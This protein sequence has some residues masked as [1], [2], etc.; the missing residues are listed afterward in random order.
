MK[1]NIERSMTVAGEITIIG[2]T[3][4]VCSRTLTLLGQ[5]STSGSKT[6][7]LLG[8]TR[9][10]QCKLIFSVT[11]SSADASQG[12]ASG[13]GEVEYGQSITIRAAA[14]SGYAF[15]HWT[16]NGAAVQGAGAVYSYAPKGND[17][18]VAYFKDTPVVFDVVAYP[19]VVTD[20][21]GNMFW[22]VS[23]ATN[24]DV[25]AETTLEVSGFIEISGGG[26]GSFSGV[27]E[28]G[29]GKNIL[30]TS[31]P[32]AEG[33]DNVIGGELQLQCTDASY[34]VGNVEFGYISSFAAQSILAGYSLWSI[35]ADDEDG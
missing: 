28:R 17:A 33:C 11:V 20:D 18:W 12:T 4:S 31:I 9:T 8:E 13:G 22:A 1:E 27:L 15:S 35:S 21:G 30:V 7:T 23:V 2:E 24:P 16:K 3:G 32:Y 10:L 19:M 6:I 5:T 25:L 29:S 14:K 26:G 34:V